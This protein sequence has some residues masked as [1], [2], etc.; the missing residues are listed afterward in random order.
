VKNLHPESLVFGTVLDHDSNHKERVYVEAYH[1]EYSLLLPTTYWYLGRSEET[2]QSGEFR[3][4][5]PDDAYGV[6][7]PGLLGIFEYPNIYLKITDQYRKLHEVPVRLIVGE[8]N[9]YF[10]V[11]IPS[12]VVYSDQIDHVDWDELIKNFLEDISGLPRNEV[13]AIVPGFMQP[14]VNSKYT[15]KDVQTDLNYRG[16]MVTERPKKDPPPHSHSIPWYP[17]WSEEE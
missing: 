8:W 17:T 12:D 14:I 5:F 9:N 6:I 3:I 7:G 16:E 4:T 10:D 2:D 13:A 15:R 1:V 11:E